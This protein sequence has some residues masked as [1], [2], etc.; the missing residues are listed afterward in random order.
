[1]RKVNKIILHCS[2]TSDYPETADNFDRY[3]AYDIDQWHRDRGF[4]E[5]GY[6]WVVRRTGVIECGRPEIYM[7]AHCKGQ[8][9]NSIGVCYIGTSKPT[10]YQI[11]SLYVLITGLMKRYKLD[12]KDFFGHKDFAKTACP[13]FDMHALVRAFLEIHIL[14]LETIGVSHE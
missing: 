5:I 9:E 4:D 8:N 12:F 7:G 6:H 14:D 3:G 1:M 13:G 11:A 10:C 2:A